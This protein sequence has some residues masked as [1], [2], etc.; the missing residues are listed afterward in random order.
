MA[1]G[2]SEISELDA[3]LSRLR[4]RAARLKPKIGTGPA[5]WQKWSDT[6]DEIASVIEMMVGSPAPHIA[7]LALQFRAIL[8]QI[9]TD[10]SLLDRGDARRLRRFRRNLD[11]LA[12]L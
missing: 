10:Q 7:D 3:E 8:W 6:M 1:A 11:R 9:E 4:R 2:E 12:G 5:A